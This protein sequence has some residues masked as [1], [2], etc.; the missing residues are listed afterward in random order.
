MGN[1]LSG[2]VTE[3]QQNEDVHWKIFNDL[4]MQDEAEMLDLA[5]FL[6]TILGTCCAA[7]AR[8]QRGGEALTLGHRRLPPPPPRRAT[9]LMQNTYRSTT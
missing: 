1:R 4:D 7:D 9:T 2:D 5:V 3:W 6:Q 8:R